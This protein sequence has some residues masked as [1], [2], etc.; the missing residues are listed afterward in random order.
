MRRAGL[1]PPALAAAV[2]APALLN[3]FVYDD[4]MIVRDNPAVHA[5][6]L[7]PWVASYWPVGGLYR[8]LTIQLFQLQWLAGGGSPL[9]FH[10]VS[11]L[12][13]A[14]VAWCAWRLFRHWLPEG[15]ALAAACLFAVHPVHVEAVANV[16]GQSELLVALLALAAVERFLAWRDE[17]RLDLPR[18]AALVALT[19]LGILS[20][21]TGFVIPVLILAAHLSP[22]APRHLGTSARRHV[23]TTFALLLA[24][25]AAALLLRLIIL[26]SLSGETPSAA[27]NGV[28]VGTRL[29]GMLQVVPEWGR[30]LVW[31]AHL[32]A[33]YG[34]PDLAMDAPFGLRHLAGLGLI[35]GFLGLLAWSWRRVSAAA[36]GLLW[37]AIA[38]APVS[39][40]LAPTGIV[41]AERTLFLPSVGFV[42][43]L[44]SL[45]TS[46][47]Q[48]PGAPALGYFGRVAF[49][50]LLGLAALRSVTRAPVWRSEEVFYP[51]MVRDA[52][53]SYRAHLMASRWYHGSGRNPPALAEARR[54]LELYRADP[55]VY[56]QVGQVLRVEGRC[57]EALPVLHEGIE[58]FPAG[59][60]IRSR[61]IECAL[62]VGDTALALRAAE[63][64]VVLGQKEFEG[65][66]RRLG[67]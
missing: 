35:A 36:F 26:S 1:L 55:Q 46:A 57:G 37:T 64:A 30:L 45:G 16:V 14:L 58:R 17:G 9:L 24:T 49:L 2:G 15:A 51:A 38:L 29:A 52:P 7:Q 48:H 20:K 31:P 12:L 61:Y 23:G 53:G 50:A 3:G 22:S 43:A 66:V 4:V 42:L 6:S 33:E 63:D 32:Q 62:A 59:T 56:E 44:V 34:P 25:I 21:E 11:L 19:L 13:A 18:R 28:P 8:P 67:R 47:L 5:L 10:A 40:L 65:T 39:N 41:L 27:F 54:A 60:V